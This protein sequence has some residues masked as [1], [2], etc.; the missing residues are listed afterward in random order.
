[1]WILNTATDFLPQNSLYLLWNPTILPLWGRDKLAQP[2]DQL[3]VLWLAVDDDLVVVHP[4][5][6]PFSQYG[7]II[8][9]FE[10]TAASLTAVVLK[11]REK[12]PS[13]TG[14]PPAGLVVCT[15]KDPYYPPA[16]TKPLPMLARGLAICIYL[17][18]MLLESLHK[19]SWIEKHLSI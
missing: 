6:I 4:T 17:L 12:V 9:K 10:A 14:Q 3:C 5:P 11:M 16:P 1:M 13:W 2:R 8:L 18:L 15:R 19:K 7:L